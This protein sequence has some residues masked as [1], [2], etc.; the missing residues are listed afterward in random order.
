MP[1]S[2]I[3]RYAI[4]AGIFAV[5][6]VPFI[7]ANPLFFPFITGKN[8]AFRIIVEVVT[9]LWVILALVDPSVRPK[10]SWLLYAVLGLVVALGLSDILGENPSKSFWSN[11]ERMEGWITFVH[12]G[13]YFVVTSSM[14][15]G[16]KLWRRF[17]A[18]QIGA[19][20]VMALYGVF[21]LAGV[22]VINQ[23]GVR[24]DG[25]FGNATYLA[26]YMLISF[27]MTLLAL[28]SWKPGRLA[29]IG[30][31]AAL[32]LQALMIFYSA[33]RGTILGVLG[34]LLLTGIIF[35]VFAKGEQK[36]RTWGAALAL[37][38]VLLMGGFSLIK[39]T[40]FVQNHGVLTRLASISLKDGHTRFAIWNMALLGIK[41][42]PVLGW[43]QENFNY[44]FNKYYEPSMYNQE[45]WFDRAHNEFLDITVAGGVVSLAF[46]LALFGLALWYLWKPGSSFVLAER[47][48]MT[49]LIA[50]YGFHN[51]FV[52]DNLFSYVLFFTLLAYIAS[53]HTATAE[54]M[55]ADVSV[56]P[57]IA[58]AGSAAAVVGLVCAL[59]F[60]NVPGLTRAYHLIEGLKP[61]GTDLTENF[62]YFKLANAG[63]G[64]GRQEAHE[65]LL[66]FAS[67]VQNPQ[68]ASLSTP[69]LRSEILTYTKDEFA[70]ETARVPNDARLRLF[71]GSFLNQM[72]D[73]AGALRELTRAAELSP[74]KQTILFELGTLATQT[75]DAESALKWFKTAYDLEP[76]VDQ[77]RI[78]YAA[79]LIRTTQ[80]AAASALLV[81]KFGTATP[82][83][84]IILQ[85]YFD[86]GDFT[87]VVAIAEGRTIL[88][89]TDFNA[90]VQLGA[91]Y[92]KAGH[93]ANSITALQKAID[94]NPDFKAQGEYYIQEIKAGR[95]P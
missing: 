80:G 92:L 7:V 49:G 83:N 2:K 19:S 31:A 64:I 27:F 87:S 56:M 44:L 68:L 67:Q 79:T 82:D 17:F 84:D 47:A 42:R 8:F 81:E 50:G 93:R 29:Q 41:E 20:V 5:L 25:T 70:N 91:A 95:N 46:Y 73:T 36:F 65:Q 60:L 89:P 11:F 58:Q 59:W 63:G 66:Q 4:I 69:E 90:F 6:F 43:G 77:A 28:A 35:V 16:E 48:V 37:L 30:L 3:L 1:T 71:Y 53:R 78:N 72:G 13:L 94:L 55:N 23:G 54:P 57:A 18:T 21:Q 14:L 39:D 33:T 75:G 76:V 52:F 74:R 10:K 86:V 51:L 9:A 32:V 85:A 62:R 12:L 15:Q 61:H 26:V 38:V 88:R 24:V 40:P 34:G 22:F 45:P